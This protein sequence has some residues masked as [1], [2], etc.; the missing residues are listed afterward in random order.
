MIANSVLGQPRGL[1]ARQTVLGLA[2]ELGIADEDRQH[3]LA[4]VEDVVGGDLRRLLLPDQFAERAQSPGQRG[5]QPRLV[6]AAGGGRDGVAIPGVAAVGPQRPGDRP[7]AAALVAGKVLPPA[8]G[9]GGRALPAPEIGG[10]S[11]SEGGD[12]YG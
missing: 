1:G 2:L 6:G 7:S 11:W 4:A 3:H 8:A 9:F 5:T 10:G 12:R